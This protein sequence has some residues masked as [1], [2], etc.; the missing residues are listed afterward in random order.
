MIGCEGGGPSGD[1]RRRETA[2]RGAR[3]DG[4]GREGRGG[5]EGR[6]G[7]REAGG[8]GAGVQGEEGEGQS[9]E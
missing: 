4:A 1:A 3:G 6:G 9:A 2:P 5:T 8:V 7:A